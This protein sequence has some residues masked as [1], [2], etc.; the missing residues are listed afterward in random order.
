MGRYCAAYC[1]KYSTSKNWTYCDLC[2]VGIGID[3]CGHHGCSTCGMTLCIKHQ[4][5]CV[6]F[7]EDKISNSLSK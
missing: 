6:C 2:N 7:T 4:N 1:K 5:K 3:C